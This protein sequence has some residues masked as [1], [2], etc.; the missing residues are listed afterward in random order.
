MGPLCHGGCPVPCLHVC[1]WHRT[2]AASQRP[3]QSCAVPLASLL[4]DGS[5]S[6]GMGQ[7]C[8]IAHISVR[9]NGSHGLTVRTKQSCDPPQICHV[10]PGI[11][12]TPYL[13]TF[14]MRN[15]GYF[16]P[17]PTGSVSDLSRNAHFSWCFH[18]THPFCSPICRSLP[19]KR[20]GLASMGYTVQVCSSSLLRI[21]PKP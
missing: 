1:D 6:S 18:K 20:G 14:S 3:Q 11:Q 12:V 7:E 8:G 16:S 15:L 17:D 2:P 21:S 13:P 4:N 5:G 9:S 10:T 19:P